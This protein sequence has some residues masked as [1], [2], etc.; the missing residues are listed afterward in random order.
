MGALPELLTVKE[1]SEFFKRK[2]E[3]IKRWIR[4]KKLPAIHVGREWRIKKQDIERIISGE[5][6]IVEK[7]QERK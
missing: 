3:T 6:K 1:V 4:Q 2:T 5:A 7:K